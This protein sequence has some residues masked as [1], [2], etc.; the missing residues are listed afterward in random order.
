M[1]A[2]VL[3]GCSGT[4]TGP[5]AGAPSAAAPSG[6]TSATP[7]SPAAASGSPIGTPAPGSPVAGGNVVL[8]THDSFAVSDEVVAEFEAQTGATLRVL[9]AGD[10]GSMVN[11]AI[12]ARD[13]P[14]ADVLYGVDNTFLSRALEA[15]IFVEYASPLAE[16]VAR[17]LRLESGSRATPIDYGDVCLNYDRSAFTSVPAPSGL[18]DLIEPAYRGMLVVQNPATS[19][20]GLAFLLAT[21]AHF[22]EAGDY[23]W[24]D[25]WADLRANDVAVSAGWE[26]A[27]YG[28]FS[29]GS[30]E[31]D[32]PIVV[33]YA[34]SPVAEML[35]ADPRPDEPPTAVVEQGCFRQIEFA[36]VLRGRPDT[37]P[38]AEA[39]VDFMLGARF[40]EDVPLNMFVFPANREAE[41]PPE[42]A[43]YSAAINA[44]LTLDPAA[45]DAGRERWIEEWTDVVLR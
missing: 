4:G 5:S 43:E 20:P 37:Q 1:A 36:A 40:Q 32:G 27:Y 11:Q 44:P 26:D 45:I 16:T 21:V 14:L 10:A 23:T 28:S 25:Y 19:S 35:F 29:G 17:E 3:A 15:D 6:A 2:F 22:G 8:M 38:L 39:L 42:F 9:R 41:L 31:G 34:T 13:A 30:G 33:S 18:E 12:L 7:G 24:R